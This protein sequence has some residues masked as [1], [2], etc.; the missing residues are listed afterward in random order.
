MEGVCMRTTVL[1]DDKLI[2]DA[3][4][5]TG[6]KK[7]SKV[8]NEVLNDYVQRENARRLALLVGSEPDLVVL[9]RRRF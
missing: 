3:K 1:L 6:Q 8:I 2:E 7:T 4:T 9:P 5:L